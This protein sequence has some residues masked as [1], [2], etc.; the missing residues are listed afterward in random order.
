MKWASRLTLP[1]LCGIVALMS[2]QVLRPRFG[3]EHFGSSLSSFVFT[4]LGIFFGG[5]LAMAVGLREGSL[6]HRYLGS[7]FLRFFGKYSYCLYICHLPLIMLIVKIGLRSDKLAEIL[8]NKLLAVI[9]VNGIAFATAIAVALA[10]WHLFEK[11]WLKLKDL[12]FL[13][14]V[15]MGRPIFIN[16]GWSRNIVLSRAM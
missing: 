3:S 14:R 9:A 7:P 6:K 16:G 2:L 4:L 12:S 11:Q 10:S 13:Q 1:A 15:A 5:C 8:G